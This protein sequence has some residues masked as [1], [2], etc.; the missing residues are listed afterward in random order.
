MSRIQRGC[1]FGRG[2]VNNPA[3]GVNKSNWV[4]DLAMADAG[5]VPTPNSVTM[6]TKLLFKH[7][8]SL[9]EQGSSFWQM[10]FCTLCGWFVDDEC[11]WNELLSSLSSEMQ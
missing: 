10:C 9:T 11:F 5:D 3:R 6:E 1:L 4:F 7:A 2:R 8:V